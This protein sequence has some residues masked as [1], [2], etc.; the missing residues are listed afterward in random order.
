M[1]P[2]FVTLIIVIGLLVWG[3]YSQAVNFDSHAKVNLVQGMEASLDVL[4]QQ[5]LPRK[6]PSESC[7][8][9][10]SGPANYNVEVVVASLEAESEWSGLASTS[11]LNIDSHHDQ[12]GNLQ[13][14]LPWDTLP[15]HEVKP[16]QPQRY[17]ITLTYE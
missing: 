16:L 11:G 2:P 7:Q 4:E 10:L 8:F 5:T 15:S 12:N 1:R 13:L 17:I 14:D 3:N 6:M 9:S